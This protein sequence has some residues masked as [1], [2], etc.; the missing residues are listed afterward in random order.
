M[1]KITYLLYAYFLFAF[2]S[3]VFSQNIVI[4]EIL[5]S[6]TTSIQDADGSH[7]DWIELHNKGAVSVNLLGYGISD[8]VLL[9]YKWIFP[10]VS[11]AAGQ[12]LIVWA[13]DKNRAVAGSPLHTNFKISASGESIYL[14]NGVGVT[15]DNVPAVS[16]QANISYGR[17]PN[18]TGPFVYFGIPTP[19]AVNSSTGY[20]G[21]LNPPTFSQVAGFYPSSFSLTISS[22]DPGTTILYTLDGSEPSETNLGGTT[23][24][25]K[26]VYIETPGQT[27]GPLLNNS[28]QTLQYSAPITIIDR[29]S[30]PNAHGACYD[31]RALGL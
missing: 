14:T 2:H 31:P 17:S 1:K 6:N 3:T 8:D 7:E 11:I 25:Y 5:A 20:S 4:N 19:N 27:A 10:N 18:G 28:Y 30:Q 26:N 21:N 13:S 24:T 23:Y 12:Y 16:L 29:S 22:T 15:V 9:P